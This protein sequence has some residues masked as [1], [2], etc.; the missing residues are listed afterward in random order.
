MKVK[1]KIKYR[2]LWL[3]MIG[4]AFLLT[5]LVLMAVVFITEDHNYALAILCLLI[6]KNNLKVFI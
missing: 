3:F 2:K 5:L 6:Y 4:V 1:M